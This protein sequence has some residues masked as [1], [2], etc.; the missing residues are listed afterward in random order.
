MPAQPPMLHISRSSPPRRTQQP[1]STNAESSHHLQELLSDSPR[2]PYVRLA[3]TVDCAA[4]PPHW[5]LT[6]GGKDLDIS[7]ED[8]YVLSANGEA[9][10]STSG[11][12]V[13]C[14]PLTAVCRARPG[15]LRVKP[16]ILH[17]RRVFDTTTSPTS[18][19]VSASSLL[20]P[21]PPASLL[22][23]LLHNQS[24]SPQPSSGFRIRDRLPPT[25][26]TPNTDFKNLCSNLRQRNALL[27]AKAASPEVPQ[28]SPISPPTSP[29]VSRTPSSP[30]QQRPVLHV[31]TS[32]PVGTSAPP[33]TPAL[34]SP[35]PS[36]SQFR[37]SGRLPKRPA[38][39]V[40]PAECYPRAV[41][42]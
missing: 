18:P 21:S 1:M 4:A 35:S 36:P 26:S 19:T 33:P 40:W 29:A 13:P 5:D 41:V 10:S 39:P 12:L 22:I 25:P 42:V 30:R 34:P 14:E 6:S 23:T 7:E 15:R 27:A 37:P 17:R 28:I 2:R 24:F 3:L 38:L 31:Q 16:W 11:V 32:S 9:S 20:S 8:G